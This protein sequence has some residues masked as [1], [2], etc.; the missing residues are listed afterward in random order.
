MEATNLDF[1][2]LLPFLDYIDLILPSFI[3]KL[4]VRRKQ[5]VRSK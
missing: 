1:N 3:R 2:N 5:S 4:C